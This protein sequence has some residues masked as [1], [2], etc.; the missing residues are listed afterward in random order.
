M[1]DDEH[2]YA[3]IRYVERNP[4][5]A[6]IV[7][8]SETYKWSS[9]YAHVLE[10]EDPLLSMDCPLIEVMEDW[11]L[12][13]SQPDNDEWME[14]FRVLS[15]TGRPAGGDSFISMIESQLGR[16]VKP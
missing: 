4:V 11:N 10:K 5:R 9:T 6:K 1:L 14:R 7:Q 12:Y 3:A 16:V 8:Q 13:L 2:L 15:R